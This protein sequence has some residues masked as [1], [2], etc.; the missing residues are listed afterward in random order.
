MFHCVCI[1][2]WFLLQSR[3]VAATIKSK[4]KSAAVRNCSNFEDFENASKSFKHT[5]CSSNHSQGYSSQSTGFSSPLLGG[6]RNSTQSE[7]TDGIDWEEDFG[8]EDDDDF[9]DNELL[10]LAA[11]EAEKSFTDSHLKPTQWQTVNSKF[12]KTLEKALMRPK[13]QVGKLVW[14]HLFFY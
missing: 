3:K 4:K 11:A 2:W 1:P 5:Q 9:G 8:E 7:L 14:I 13:P 6:S 10:C 12:D